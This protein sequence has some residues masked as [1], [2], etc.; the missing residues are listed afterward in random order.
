MFCAQTRQLHFEREA[1]ETRKLVM[2]MRVAASML[3]VSVV[4]PASADVQCGPPDSCAGTCNYCVCIITDDQT[5]EIKG[6]VMYQC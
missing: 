6:W 5:G 4:K 1:V 2:L 3:T